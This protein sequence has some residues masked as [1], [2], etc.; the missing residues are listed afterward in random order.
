MRWWLIVFVVPSLLLS[1]QREKL[2]GKSSSGK[3][4]R[5]IYLPISN[6]LFW[7]E[8]VVLG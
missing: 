3:A 2:Q 4:R 1:S 7:K 6:S 8:G 5:G